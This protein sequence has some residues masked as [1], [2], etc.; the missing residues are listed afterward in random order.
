MTH[1]FCHFPWINFGQTFHEHMSR[2]CFIFL[3]L[4]YPICDQPTG[5]GKRSAMPTLFPSPTGHPT[6]V[7]FLSDFCW[8]IYRF[9]AIH[10]RKCPCQQCRYLDG[11]TVAPHSSVG[12]TVGYAYQI[13][14]MQWYSMSTAHFLVVSY[15]GVFSYLNLLAALHRTNVDI[16]FLMMY[17]YVT[18]RH[19]SSLDSKHLCGACR[20]M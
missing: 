6:D 1:H 8:G 10:L 3:L 14:D 4:G 18:V 19:W 12:A 2:W 20:V 15:T 17:H 11:D 16:P 9:A 13:A 5:H 7:P